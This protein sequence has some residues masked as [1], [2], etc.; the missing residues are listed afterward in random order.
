MSN[1]TP[2]YKKSTPPNQG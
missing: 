1:L 2:V